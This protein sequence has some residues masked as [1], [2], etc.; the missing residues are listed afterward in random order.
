MNDESLKELLSNFKELYEEGLITAAEYEQ[1]KREVL[2][3]RVRASSNRATSAQSRTAPSASNQYR[4]VP[5]GAQQVGT[6]PASQLAICVAAADARA[7][8]R[9]QSHYQS[10]SAAP[11]GGH[12]QAR[13]S[14]AAA[15]AP[16]A[17]SHYQTRP[18][19]RPQSLTIDRA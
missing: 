6:R 2:D 5:T 1:K 15:P 11:S 18:S 7:R 19:A 10:H 13:P 3:M 8:A 9:T 4:P 12:Y 16:A 14:Q 17:G